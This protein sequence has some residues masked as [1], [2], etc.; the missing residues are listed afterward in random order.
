MN[1]SLTFLEHKK[2]QDV[3]E[4]YLAQQFLDKVGI[5][6]ISQIKNI[7]RVE[8]KNTDHYEEEM[9]AF[10]FDLGLMY[11]AVVAYI[12]E[13][14]IVLKKYPISPSDSTVL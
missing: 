1:Q 5:T 10:K 6:V 2:I 11:N 14:R 3:S 8:D 12:E 4:V 13:S 7:V 9:R